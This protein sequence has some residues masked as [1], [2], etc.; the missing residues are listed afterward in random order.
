MSL[1]VAGGTGAVGRCVVLEA[2]RRP[3]ITRVVALTRS[4][5]L[6]P[7]TLFGASFNSDAITNEQRSRLRVLTFD[8]EYFYNFWQ[9]QQQSTGGADESAEKYYRE[10]FSGH[11]YAAMCLGTTRHDAGSA[12]AFVH[13]DYDYTV[14]FAWAVKTFSGSSLATY[15][16]ISARLAN[17]NSWILYS[18]TKGRADAAVEKFQFPRLCIY[19]PGLLDRGEKTRFKEKIAKWF[20]KGLPVEICGKAVVVD[21]VRS[22]TFD[23][24]TSF[25]AF[26]NEKVSSASSAEL[27]QEAKVIYFGNKD[28]KKMADFL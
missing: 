18:K 23:G 10:I 24:M 13:C 27:K 9:Q 8:W 15:A 28:I 2:L 21:F 17:K 1:I 16:Q 11:K 14:A 22:A 20:V 3:E 6:D 19:R 7:V 12:A 5:S 26:E 25:R 4:L